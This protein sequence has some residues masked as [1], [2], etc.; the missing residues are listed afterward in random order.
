MRNPSNDF[1]PGCL[2]SPWILENVDESVFFLIHECPAGDFE[3]EASTSTIVLEHW[4][5]RCERLEH[6]EH[7]DRGRRFRRS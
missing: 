6:D 4:R 2:R 1:C 5:R 7:P 3:C